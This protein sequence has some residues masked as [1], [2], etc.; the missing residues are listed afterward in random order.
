MNTQ[1]AFIL[2]L[3]ALS[4]AIAALIKYLAPALSIAPSVTNALIAVLSPSVILALILTWRAQT[5]ALST[6]TAHAHD[7][8]D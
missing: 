4:G 1:L 8:R 5:P 6:P 7:R 2:K 3:L